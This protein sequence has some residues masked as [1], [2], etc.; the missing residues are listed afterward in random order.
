MNF[1]TA[2]QLVKHYIKDRTGEDVHLSMAKI[3]P[4]Q[5]QLE[6]LEDAVKIINHYYNEGKVKIL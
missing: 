4:D 6:M 2:I 5:R 1:N 3:A